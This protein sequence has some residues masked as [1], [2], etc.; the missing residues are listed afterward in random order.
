MGTVVARDLSFHCLELGGESA[1]PDAPP[2]VMIHGL[3]VA[4]LASWYLTAAPRVADKRRVFLYDQR[5]HGKSERPASGY[6][7]A[8]M[9]ADLAALLEAWGLS[10]V[11]LVGHSYG[12]LV[13]LRFALD[14]PDRVSELVLVEAPLPPPRFDGMD[15]FL[16][17][18]PEKMLA[19]LPEIVQQAV[20]GGNR[21]ARKFVE[22]VSALTFDTT[23]VKDIRAEGDIPDAELAR[24]AA[25]TLCI[26]GRQSS[27][28]D[29]GERLAKVLPSATLT[30]LEGGHFL[31][32]DATAA[33]T[34]TI[35][36]FFDG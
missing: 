17:Q 24:L 29:V 2:V 1:R 6:G 36:E 15:A 25:R 30:V 16:E 18:T 11:A 3:L 5:G 19:A 12:A 10:R 33:L 13:A 35:A 34:T 7:V 9:A 14:H 20:S 4:S 32:L 23:L 28:L 27:C 21:Q 22:S 8:N 31:H 26:Y